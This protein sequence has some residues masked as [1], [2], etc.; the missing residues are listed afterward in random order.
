MG[1]GGGVL[2]KRRWYTVKVQRATGERVGNAA[3]WCKNAAMKS[4]LRD[5]LDGK[6][7]LSFPAFYTISVPVLIKL[8][9]YDI[10]L[11]ILNLEKVV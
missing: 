3:F 1:E 2:A 10:I 7:A 5:F 11:T 9:Q 4:R 8:S 6:I